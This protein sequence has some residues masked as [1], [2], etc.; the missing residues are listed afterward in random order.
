MKLQNAVIADVVSKRAKAL[1][2]L[3]IFGVLVLCV[4]AMAIR[5][6][7]TRTE[8]SG[9]GDSM[10][11]IRDEIRPIVSAGGDYPES[12]R[13]YF[14]HYGLGMGEGVRHRFGTF[15]SGEWTLAGHVYTPGEYRET[16]I[17]LHGYLNHCGQFRHLIRRLLDAGYAVAMYDMP[18]HGLSTGERAVIEDFSQY[19]DALGDFLEVVRGLAH[20]PYDVI[21][22]STGGTVA[23]DWLLTRDAEVFRRVV[24]AGPLVRSPGW[25]S[26]R[27]GARF[28]SSFTDT[29]PRIARKNCSDPAYLKFNKY[30][31][32]L[33]C[34]NVSLRWLLA[35]YEW[36][37]RMA[38]R[39]P[40]A[41]GV[42]VIQGTKDTTVSFKYNLAFI[43]RKFPAADV[44][45]IEGGRHELFNE[46]EGLREKVLD[47]VV[48]Y[49]GAD[50]SVAD[51]D[52]EDLEDGR[53]G[54]ATEGRTE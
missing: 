7:C 32:M 18:G 46:A 14:D 28:Y 44:T 40:S 42:K 21:G 4:F 29:V 16:V 20:G 36:N 17:L 12:V 22:F 27:A 3:P 45:L 35:L 38:D 2:M 48:A 24:L 49:L 51:E 15:E 47:A 43:R 54:Y 50:E 13:A 26:S 6:A 34:R 5:P 52:A 37:D 31:D 19:S 53:N 1:R 23:I 41:C 25:Q 33:H 9:S 10:V 39:G 8:V 30:S 11:R